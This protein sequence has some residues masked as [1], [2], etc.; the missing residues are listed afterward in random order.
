MLTDP[1]TILCW[2][3]PCED[4]NRKTIAR[5]IALAL[6]DEVADLEHAGIGIIQIDSSTIREGLPLKHSAWNDYLIWTV[7]TFRLNAR[8]RRTTPSFPYPYGL[9]RLQR[10]YGFYCCT[11]C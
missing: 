2:Y 6:C 1:I 11:G 5:Q 8:W 4:V 10:H 7:E 9:L 3:F